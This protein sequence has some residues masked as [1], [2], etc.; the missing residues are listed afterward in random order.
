MIYIL[1]TDYAF[2]IVSV[3]PGKNDI[4]APNGR[5]LCVVEVI[6]TIDEYGDFNSHMFTYNRAANGV[7]KEGAPYVAWLYDYCF[8]IDDKSDIIRLYRYIFK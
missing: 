6:K 2:R 1:F 4:S 3:N 7:Y 5:K 8:K